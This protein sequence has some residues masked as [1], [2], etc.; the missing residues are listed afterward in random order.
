ME[1][2]R[3]SEEHPQ[4]KHTWISCHDQVL[5]TIVSAMKRIEDKSTHVFIVDIKVNLHQIKQALACW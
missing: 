1:E 2:Y 3:I 5:L 4:E